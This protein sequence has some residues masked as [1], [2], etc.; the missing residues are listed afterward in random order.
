[1]ATI[2][3]AAIEK[4]AGEEGAKLASELAAKV[5][6]AASAFAGDDTQKR[7]SVKVLVGTTLIDV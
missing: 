5:E 4:A 6:D 7:D 3:V 1:V 2:D